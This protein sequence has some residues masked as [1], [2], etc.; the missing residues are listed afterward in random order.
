MNLD[1]ECY[2][3]LFTDGVQGRTLLVRPARKRGSPSSPLESRVLQAPKWK[4][5]YSNVDNKVSS[6]A[7]TSLDSFIPHDCDSGPTALG[8]GSIEVCVRTRETCL[9]GLRLCLYDLGLDTLQGKVVESK[10]WREGDAGR[11]S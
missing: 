8:I 2:W 7:S 11:Q 10:L 3:I 9:A 6:N 5:F 1:Y 4:D